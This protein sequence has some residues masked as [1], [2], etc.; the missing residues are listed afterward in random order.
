MTRTLS[1]ADIEALFAEHGSVPG[2][3]ALLQVGGVLLPPLRSRV[4]TRELLYTA[5]TRQKQK[6]V[7]LHQGSAT[8]LQSEGFRRLLV[9]SVYWGTGLEVPPK[10]DVALVGEY[11]ATSFAKANLWD[12][13]LDWRELNRR[14][15]PGADPERGD[16]DD[17]EAAPF[18]WEPL[19]SSATPLPMSVPLPPSNVEKVSAEPLAFS[20]LTKASPVPLPSR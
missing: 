15:A 3:A 2:G 5:L 6:V 20:A 9:N 4:V 17:R 10:A 1:L 13:Y 16:S 18:T 8:D 14:V 7:V 12:E 11:K 19:E